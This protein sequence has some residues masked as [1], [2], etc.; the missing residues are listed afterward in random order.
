MKKIIFTI[1]FL[2]SCC[3]ASILDDCYKIYPIE[4]D[5]VYMD[6]IDALSSSDKFE[7]V[8][9]QSKNGYILFQYGAKYCLLTTTKRYKNQT[10]VK[11]LPQNSDYSQGATVANMVFQL[12][13][14][15]IKIPAEK[16]K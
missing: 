13:D 12:M 15:S 14:Y 8:E 2:F 11:I 5:I 4:A 9:L 10:E 6:A 3:F 16:I 7:I 1:C